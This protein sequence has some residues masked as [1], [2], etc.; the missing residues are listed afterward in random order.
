MGAV[1][2]GQVHCKVGTDPEYRYEMLMLPGALDTRGKQASFACPFS[3]E[4]K[5][6][7][8]E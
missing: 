4:K 6:M 2:H 8:Y 3:I 1:E 5:N 7:H